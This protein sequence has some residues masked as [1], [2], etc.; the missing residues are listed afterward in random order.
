MK[1]NDFTLIEVI[2]VLA[3]GAMVTGGIITAIFQVS[4][5][6]IRTN[7]QVVPLTDAIMHDEY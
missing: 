4:Q 5:G 7:D 2:V 1:Q 6:T 3:V